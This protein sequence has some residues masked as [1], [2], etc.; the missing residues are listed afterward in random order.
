MELP[1]ITPETRRHVLNGLARNPS[2]PDGVLRRLLQA[3]WA[4]TVMAGKRTD[5]TEQLALALLELDYDEVAVALGGNRSLPASVR[6]RLAGH[7]AARIRQAAARSCYPPPGPGCETPPALL[8]SLATDPDP[9]VRALVAVHPSTPDSERTWLATD[10]DV[11]VRTALATRWHTPTPAVHRALLTDS[12]PAVRAAACSEWAP[13]PPADLHLTLLAA[14]ET[15][16][17]AA[18][19]VELTPALAAELARDPDEDVRAAVAGRP[20]LPVTLREE[21]AAEQNWAVRLELLLSPHLPQETRARLYEEV[22]AAD[23][24]HDEWFLVEAVL[25]AAW[26]GSHQLSW[27]HEAPVT[28]QLDLLDSP[29]RYLRRAVARHAGELPED[30]VTRLLRDPDPQVQKIAAHYA[31]NP[32]AGELERIVRDFGDHLKIRPGIAE[33]PDFPVDAL[34]R[35]A[36]AKDS[37]PRLWRI[38]AGAALP[39]ATLEALARDPLPTVRAAAA[40]N[41]ALPAHCL[42]ALLADADPNV[43]EAAGSSANL[44]VAW[45]EELLTAEGMVPLRGSRR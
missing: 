1:T 22:C 13:A 34:V 27:L 6:I 35:L 37:H 14:P 28:D 44:P 24:D 29:F 45:M 18:R 5:L 43:S 20:E 3:P 42:P 32:P 41:P 8:A 7:P 40:A 31:K 2:A 12:E 26:M 9:D 10:P 23:D 36:T 19:H 39:P 4:A 16:A 25:D 15:R 17:K 38:I 21:L 33:R 11:K 30:V